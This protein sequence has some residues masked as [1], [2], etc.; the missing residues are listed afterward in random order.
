MNRIFLEDGRIVLRPLKIDDIENGYI[1]WFD[2]EKICNGNNHHRFPYSKEKMESY[3]YESNKF[4]NS[5]ILA[6]VI[7]ETNKHVGN[8]ALDPID[9]I[10]SNATLSI[11]IGDKNSWGK[12]IGYSAS[13]L[14]VNHAFKNLNIKRINIAT[15]DYNLGMQ[16]IAIKL[17]AKEEGRRRKAIF[18]NGKYIDIIEYGLLI[19]EF[20][21]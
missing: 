19:D 2:S 16:K 17:G 21:E 4:V 18:K 1:N 15:F 11:I 14:I 7:K 3:V 5:L 13:K 6:I 10:N 12:K 20:E 8:I 9:F